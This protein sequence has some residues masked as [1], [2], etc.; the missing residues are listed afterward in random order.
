[1][2]DVIPFIIQLDNDFYLNNF[3]MILYLK[4]ILMEN[5]QV[6]MRIIQ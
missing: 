4:Y 5:I 3:I 2:Y 6:I 1:M